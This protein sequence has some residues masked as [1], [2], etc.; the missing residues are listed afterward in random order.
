MLFSRFSKPPN[1]LFPKPEPVSD[2]SDWDAERLDEGN[3]SA[4]YASTPWGVLAKPVTPISFERE[5]PHFQ[6]LSRKLEE[7]QT[8]HRQ[9]AWEST[10]SFPI[11]EDLRRAVKYFAILYAERRQRRSRFGAAWKSFL[12][13]VLLCI[14]AGHCDLLDP[15]FLHFPRPGKRSKWYSGLHCTPR[16]ANLFQ[17]LRDVDRQDPWRNQYRHAI[18]N[19]PG[20]QLPRLE[21]KFIPQE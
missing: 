14:V 13:F 5:S 1:R 17:A 12:K 6:T 20:S 21:G 18:E 3:V 19:H 2:D 11:S 7:L 16:P 8:K 10:H 9:A 4:V 15:V